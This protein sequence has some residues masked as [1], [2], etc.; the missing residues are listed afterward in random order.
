MPVRYNI[1]GTRMTPAEIR[2]EA[3]M[4]GE[5]LSPETK[6]EYLKT[7]N[8]FFSME[9]QKNKFI[10][11]WGPLI[12]IAMLVA[13]GWIAFIKPN[14]SQFQTGV[15]W[16]LLSMGMA[17]SAVLI[18]GYFEFKHENWIKA[19]GGFAIFAVMYFYVPKIMTMDLKASARLVLNVVPNDTARFEAIPVE[20]DRNS[21]EDICAF[22]A[23]ALS[24]YWGMSIG[25]KEFINYRLPD[26]MIFE[27]VSCR[28]AK[29]DTVM[30]VQDSVAK[31]FANKRVAYM[32]FMKKFHH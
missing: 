3:Y 29:V 6:K 9:D 14:P 21:S 5:I 25:P 1:E 15:F 22:T 7:I 10:R 19:S 24:K 23:K 31:N 12:G 20:F 8:R 11:I 13:C 27:N 16:M 4:R 17:I 32:Y 2:H 26:G 18:A 28:D 30:M